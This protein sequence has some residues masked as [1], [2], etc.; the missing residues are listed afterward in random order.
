MIILYTKYNIKEFICYLKKLKTLTLLQRLDVSPR[1]MLQVV[2]L[3][4]HQKS[5]LKN[6]KLADIIMLWMLRIVKMLNMLSSQSHRNILVIKLKNSNKKQNKL[7][8][9]MCCKESI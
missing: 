1:I 3:H 6:L 5:L 8:Q 9:K 2:V 4:E 7:Y